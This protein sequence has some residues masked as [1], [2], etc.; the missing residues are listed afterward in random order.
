MNN[1]LLSRETKNE[2]NLKDIIS[3]LS[4]AQSSTIK[5]KNTLQLH[6]IWEQYIV[7]VI[8]RECLY[9]CKYDGIISNMDDGAIYNITMDIHKSW[10]SNYWHNKITALSYGLCVHLLKCSTKNVHIRYQQYK[11]NVT[12]ELE[13]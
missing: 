6:D 8:S 10:M 9:T 1:P 3:I 11:K 5:Y 2:R 7:T 12:L 13:L 4:L